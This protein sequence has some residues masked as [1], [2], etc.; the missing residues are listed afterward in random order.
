MGKSCNSGVATFVFINCGI[1]GRCDII[2]FMKEKNLKFR[3]LKSNEYELFYNSL[4]AARE[5]NYYGLHVI[6][7]DKES[8][9][10]CKNF[11]L[12]DGIAGFAIDGGEFISAHKNPAKAQEFGVG[13]VLPEMVDLA[14]KNGANR[15]D[16]Y[17]DF[18]ADYYM[19]C[20]FMVVA[21]VPFN[22]VYDNPENW[23]SA[24]FGKPNVYLFA[25]AI[26]NK[27]ELLRLKESGKLLRF[28]DI[29]PYIKTVQD[30][31][32]AILYRDNL[33]EKFKGL[34]YDKIVELIK[35]SKGEN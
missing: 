27:K 35:N 25:R 34:S 33:L 4:K 5:A 3:K 28:A 18:L 16:C 8:Y 13:R 22:D 17:D 2:T 20:G 23:D 15:G 32:D 11:L 31:D 7:K 19:S 12:G 10:H 29:K 24:K 14:F 6:L 26:L 9:K 21:A 30:Y 1:C